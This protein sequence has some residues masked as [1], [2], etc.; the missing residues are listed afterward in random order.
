MPNAELALQ[1]SMGDTGRE[2]ARIGDMRPSAAAAARP[3]VVPGELDREVSFQFNGSL[4]DAV[5][6]LTRLVGYELVIKNASIF[7]QRPQVAID[8]RPRRVYDLF[9][10]LGDQAGPKAHVR[11]DPQHHLVEVVYLG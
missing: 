3:K 8:P 10:E 1:Q 11:V 9:R 2:M 6:E 5:R 4:D 7:T